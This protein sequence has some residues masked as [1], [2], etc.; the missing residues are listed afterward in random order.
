MCDTARISFYLPPLRHGDLDAQNDFRAEFFDCAYRQTWRSF[1]DGDRAD[2]VHKA[3]EK[4]FKKGGKGDLRPF[5]GA[6]LHGA[7][8]NE[9]RLLW[10]RIKRQRTVSLADEIP[11]GSPPD[12][13]LE[14]IYEAVGLTAEEEQV[15]WLKTFSRMKWPEVAETLEISEA[16][17]RRRYEEAK[18]KLQEWYVR[19]LFEGMPGP[20]D[21][22]A[23]RTFLQKSTDVEEVFR[24]VDLT[25]EEEQVVLLKLFGV[26]TCAEVHSV[27]PDER[28]G[29][30]WTQISK[31]LA[32]PWEKVCRH[33]TRAFEKLRNAY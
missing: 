19:E 20:A 18:R 16:T 28:K 29:L 22:E 17:A 25:N 5:T 24:S 12:S 14:E 1:S 6:F 15:L 9:C 30:T 4:I 33:F 10:L 8:K 13:D 2:C 23:L 27:N 11:D 32:L 21:E 31:S 26:K 3:F 7:V